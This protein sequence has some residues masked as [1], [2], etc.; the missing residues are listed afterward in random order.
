MLADMV[1]PS[2]R[3]SAHG[4][5]PVADATSCAAPRERADACPGA[6]RLHR[7]DDGGL[8]RVRVPGGV[9]DVAQAAALHAAATRLG[10]GELHL[11]SRGNVQLRG[12]REDAGPELA[13]LLSGAGLLPSL[14]HERVRNIAASPLSGLDGSG[15]RDVAGQLTELDQLLCESEALRELSGRFLFAVDD[16]RGDVAALGADVTLLAEP[17]GTTLLYLGA[18]REAGVLRVADEH[19]AAAAVVAAETFL[20]AVRESGLR[21]WRVADLA[22][23][24]AE[25]ARRTALRLGA[26]A[27][28]APLA[29]LVEKTAEAPV[30]GPVTGPSGVVALSVLAPLGR[31]TGRQWELLTRTAEREG[32]GELRMTPWRGVVVPGLTPPRAPGALAALD[33]AGLVTDPASPWRGA[34]ACAGRPGCAKS[35]T[36]VRA[37]AA[38]ALARPGPASGPVSG[39]V[40]G[41]GAGPGPGAGSG[42]SALPVYWS[43]CERRCGHPRGDRV[44]VVAG[45]DGYR[46]AVVRGTGEE[47]PVPVPA[48]SDPGAAAAA[49]RVAEGTGPRRCD[50]TRYGSGA[51]AGAATRESNRPSERGAAHGP[52][53][54]DSAT[55]GP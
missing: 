35:L 10:S 37:D 55:A 11:T 15:H 12:L 6:L 7:A 5:T 23:T 26:G 9:L 45:N 29:P 47:H 31:L 17:D 50:Q 33:A 44:E 16:G 30:P 34:G 38:A 51:L 14:A 3:P 28:D 41:Y 13:E 4:T 46:V 19:A 43:G 21:A 54:E 1:M 8:A 32:N 18:D 53:R 48:G 22:V 25:L 52:V 36:D 49:A 2:S 42:S 40:S 39:P 27:R 24:G 20:E